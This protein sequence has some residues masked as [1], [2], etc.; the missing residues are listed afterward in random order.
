VPRL[1]CPRCATVI[2]VPPGAAPRC[3]SCGF[4]GPTPAAS[5]PAPAPAA[6]PSGWASA[7]QA[8]YASPPMAG[9]VDH[10]PGWVTFAA[11]MQFIGAAAL[12]LGGLLAMVGGSFIAALFEGGLG[13]FGDVLA[14]II[15]VVGVILLL[16]GV[17]FLFMGLGL[18][19][20][21]GWAR[22]TAIVF[23]AL[24]ALFAILAIVQ[25][26]FGSLLNLVLDGLIIYAL[27]NPKSK[28][29]FDQMAR[30][31]RA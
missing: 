17:L 2:E 18:L 24:G 26:D 13:E 25:G 8:G 1:K 20:G 9:M 12:L 19:K 23:A 30:M 29:W 15:V 11:V 28:A 31:P 5:A 16:L 4:G 7:P 3:P 10:R 6:A 27:V 21:R 14:G 22:I